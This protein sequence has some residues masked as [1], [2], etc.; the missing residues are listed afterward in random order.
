MYYEKH[1]GII[2]ILAAFFVM[3]CAMID[4]LVSAVIV[5]V[6]LFCIGIWK[7]SNK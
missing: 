3:F 1:E 5:I 6:I 7:I 2:S 4:S